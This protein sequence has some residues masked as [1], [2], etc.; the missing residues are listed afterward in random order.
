MADQLK[1]DLERQLKKL[2]QAVTRGGRN[3]VREVSLELWQEVVED[4]P[5]D[6]GRARAGWM[7]DEKNDGWE[8]EAGLGDY[9]PP[10]EPDPPASDSLVLFNNVDYITALEYGSSDKAPQ[11]MLRAAVTRNRRRFKK[12]VAEAIEKELKKGGFV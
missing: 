4:T 9:P 7:V 1:A 5:V 8:P 2:T 10:D 6:T 3:G 12:I 11:G